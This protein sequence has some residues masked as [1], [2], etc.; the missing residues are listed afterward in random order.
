MFG[1][2]DYL[3]DR[4]I[5][6]VDRKVSDLAVSSNPD[7]RELIAMAELLK[8]KS[9]LIGS[10]MATKGMKVYDDIMKKDPE[11]QEL[12]KEQEDEIPDES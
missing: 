8:A 3:I 4:D 7:P 9:M 11:Y 5:E 10:L 1:L 12:M 2:K 6:L